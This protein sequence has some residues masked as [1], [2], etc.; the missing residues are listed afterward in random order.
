[1]FYA[2]IGC[3][4]PHQ[5]HNPKAE[6]YAQNYGDKHH[7]IHKFKPEIYAQSYGDKHHQIHNLK[8]RN[9]CTKLWR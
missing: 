8:T 3:N 4:K 7:Y 9:I 1:L 5:I 2:I 6:I